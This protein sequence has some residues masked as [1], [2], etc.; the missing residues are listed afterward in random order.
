MSI[1]KKPMLAPSE[2]LEDFDSIKYPVLASP[3]LDGIRCLIIGGKAMS[4]TFTAIPNRHI[5]SKLQGLPNGLDGELMVTGAFSDVQSAIMSED[6][7]PDFKYY[8]FDYVSSSL[9]RPYDERMTELT[10]LALPDFCIKVLPHLI[11]NAETMRHYFTECL[12]L[13]T[14]GAMVRT[15]KGPYKCGRCTFNQGWL[16]KV[17]E[18]KDSE[19]RVIGF[20][21]QLSNNNVA[22]KDVQGKT[23]R[24]SHKANMVPAGTLGKFLVEEIG[25]TPWKGKRF[26]IGTGVGLDQALR[27]KIWDNQADYLGKIVTYKYQPHGT[28]DLPRLP[29]W[30]GFRDARD[31]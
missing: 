3:K 6:G 8:V 29:I 2:V 15:L 1:I 28:K 10:S 19:A 20:E 22:T 11:E 13:G 14:E 17:K 30:K 9:T 7:T 5:Q 26:A 12:R 27:Q 16:L 18:F 21:E 4:R 24:S 25:D 23:K 31:L